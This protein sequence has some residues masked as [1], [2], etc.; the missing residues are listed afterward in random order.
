MKLPKPKGFHI[1]GFRLTHRIL[2]IT[3]FG[4]QNP[5]PEIFE[6]EIRITFSGTKMIDLPVDFLADALELENESTPVAEFEF[7]TKPYV[8]F[9]FIFKK[10]SS[11]VGTVD[12]LIA[13]IEILPKKILIRKN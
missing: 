8:L 2:T 10:D 12:A 9:R 4:I 13:N 1:L 3:Y 5:K 7:P 11:I 6:P